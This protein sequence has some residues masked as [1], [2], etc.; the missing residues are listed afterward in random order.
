M[1]DTFEHVHEEHY[2][3]GVPL[4][5]WHS[6]YPCWNRAKIVPWKG[7]TPQHTPG[8]S[9]PCTP[10]DLRAHLSVPVWPESP[11]LSLPCWGLLRLHTRLLKQACT[12]RNFRERGWPQ[13]LQSN[14]DVPTLTQGFRG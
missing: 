1:H 11:H 3:A 9:R 8:P 12:P 7:Q 10:T 13:G 2:S 14:E 4:H 6:G 5:L